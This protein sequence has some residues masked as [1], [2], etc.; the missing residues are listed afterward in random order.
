M[1]VLKEV[2]KWP[3]YDCMNR[4]VSE[5]STVGNFNSQRSKGART[6]VEMLPEPKERTTQRETPI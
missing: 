3:N 1:L 2:N 6:K 5:L 4:V